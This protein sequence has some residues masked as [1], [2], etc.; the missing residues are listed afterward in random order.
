MIASARAGIASRH[1]GEVALR[2]PTLTAGHVSRKSADRSTSIS[3]LKEAHSWALKGKMTKPNSR[4]GPRVR[5]RV[6]TLT[7]SVSAITHDVGLKCATVRAGGTPSSPLDLLPVRANAEWAD[8]G[9][10]LTWAIC[11]TYLL[12]K[13]PSGQD[14]RVPAQAHCPAPWASG[15]AGAVPPGI[16]RANVLSL[17][18]D[19]VRMSVLFAGEL[20]A[21]PDQE[22]GIADELVLGLGNDL[23]DEFLG[24]ELPAGRCGLIQCVRFVEFTDDAAGRRTH[25]RRAASTLVGGCQDDPQV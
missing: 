9:S 12:Q 8:S 10:A 22:T 20:G 18:L 1:P 6:D 11:T 4:A 16:W 3:S 7:L 2:R 19:A 21:V 23:D 25:D 5:E 14:S 15:P 13:A 17:A 24:D